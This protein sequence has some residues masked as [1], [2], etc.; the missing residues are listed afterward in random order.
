MTVARRFIAG[1]VTPWPSS[2]RDSMIVARHEVP[3]VM[4]KNAPSQRDGDSLHRYPRHLYVFSATSQSC[5]SFALVRFSGD[6]N[7]PSAACFLRSSLFHPGKPASIPTIG[8][9]NTYRVNPGLCFLAT[10]GH[11]VE[12]SKV[13][14][15]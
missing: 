13:L 10:S 1:S 12:P 6:P 9:L 2:R 4:K 14:R 15:V 7:E 5:S 11:G 8:P 3:G